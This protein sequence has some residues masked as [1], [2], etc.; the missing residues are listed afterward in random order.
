MAAIRR[1]VALLVAAGAAANLGTPQWQ[2]ALRAYAR[3]AEAAR[4]K[5]RVAATVKAFTRSARSARSATRIAAPARA[6]AARARAMAMAAIVIAAIAIATIAIAT[7]AK[8][9]AIAARATAGVAKQ[10]ARAGGVRGVRERKGVEVCLRRAGG[11]ARLLLAAHAPVFRHR[12]QRRQRS[13]TM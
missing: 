8:A 13:C 6:I 11:W 1:V 12:Q 10:V 4:W 2:A 7:I 5:A 9:I 3:A